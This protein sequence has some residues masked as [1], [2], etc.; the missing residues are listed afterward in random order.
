MRV[1]ACAALCLH[2]DRA[3][4]RKQSYHGQ[5]T[6]LHP[7]ATTKPCPLPPPP[8]CPSFPLLCPMPPPNTHPQDYL[9]R[10]RKQLDCRS[11][12]YTSLNKE[13]HVLEVPEAAAGR[14]PASFSLVGHRKGFKRYS[15]EE[16]A[17]LVAD[18]AAAEEERERVEAGVLRV[19][20]MGAWGGGLGGC[21]H[22]SCAALGCGGGLWWCRESGA[23]QVCPDA[24][25]LSLPDVCGVSVRVCVTHP[26][27]HHP[28]QNLERLFVSHQELWASAIEAVGVLDCLMALAGAALAADGTMCRPKLLPHTLDADG[29]PSGGLFKATQLRHPAGIA[30]AACGSFVPNNVCLGG[31]APGFILLTGPNMGGKSTLLRQV[32]LAAVLA[33]VRVRGGGC[34]WG[35]AGCRE[36]GWC[37]L[38]TAL[39]GVCRPHEE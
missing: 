38:C 7:C 39:H 36:G 6:S 27:H 5:G 13:S 11:I 24:D 15:S 9:V 23:F 18:K 17:G 8:S 14:M 28:K 25:C 4:P 35:A 31:D 34:Q 30:G 16:L 33:Q 26:H 20:G 2:K 32:C 22:M 12:S 21:T 3:C 29:R 19:S 10:V 1:G 37:W